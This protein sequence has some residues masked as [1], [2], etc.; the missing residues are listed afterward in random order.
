MA[1]AQTE[2]NLSHI[3]IVEEFDEVKQEKRF[4]HIDVWG[5]LLNF[6]QA[7][8]QVQGK[9]RD[10]KLKFQALRLKVAVPKSKFEG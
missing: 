2:G 7:I 9:F 8:Q 5:V 1:I 4:Y 3:E 6:K 10:Q